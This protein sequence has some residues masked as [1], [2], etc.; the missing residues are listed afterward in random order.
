MN[1][2]LDALR[3]QGNLVIGVVGRPRVTT[4]YAVEVAVRGDPKF[5]GNALKFDS[6]SAAE[7][8]AKDLY[9]RWTAVDTWRVV[10]IVPRGW[11]VFRV[12]VSRKD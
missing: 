5:Y 9:C 2:E 11:E 8:Y 7:T 3:A 4:E 10:A 12:E 1:Q 6:V